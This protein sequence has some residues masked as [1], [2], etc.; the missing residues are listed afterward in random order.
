MKQTIKVYAKAT[1]KTKKNEIE[2]HHHWA[3]MKEFKNIFNFMEW[4]KSL[5]L[6]IETRKDF[7]DKTE[8][9]RIFITEWIKD[10]QTGRMWETHSY[11]DNHSYEHILSD[12]EINYLKNKEWDKER[13]WIT[14]PAIQEELNWTKKKLSEE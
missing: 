9:L 5:K 6:Y 3:E 7:Y 1:I 12:K 2:K 13:G 8:G 10:I 14:K 11:L 4:K